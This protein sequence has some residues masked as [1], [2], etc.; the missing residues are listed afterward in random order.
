MVNKKVKTWL[1]KL[2]TEQNLYE[3]FNIDKSILIVDFTNKLGDKKETSD[4]VKNTML[5][6]VQ[7]YLDRAKNDSID[8]KDVVSSDV[9]ECPR[10][11]K[12]RD[13]FI[14]EDGTES[15]LGD[16]EVM[17]QTFSSDVEIKVP[18]GNGQIKL[19]RGKEAQDEML[20]QHI[21]I[22]HPLDINNTFKNGS[23]TG[24]NKTIEII[25]GFSLEEMTKMVEC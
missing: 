18:D 21:A 4:N 1:D 8:V 9:I 23:L 17:V 20:R 3:K 12:M 2:F 13:G 5:E 16:S 11:L 19:L 22:F 7:M 25:G 24:K 10:C 14:S 6:L 15:Y